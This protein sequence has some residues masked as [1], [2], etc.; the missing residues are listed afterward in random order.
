MRRTTLALALFLLGALFAP[1]A[2]GDASVKIANY[3]FSPGSVSIHTG[4]KVTWNWTG[5]DKNHTVTSDPGQAESF[6]SHPGMSIIT[7]GP[8]GETFSHT[9]THTGKFTYY[10]RVHTYMT[11]TVNVSAPGTPL[12]PNDT[13]PPATTL[14]IVRTTPRRAARSGKLKV[15]VTVS[16]AATETL[17]ARLGRRKIGKK[18]VKFASAGTKTVR[19]KLTRKGKRA[20]R[21]RRRAK[22]SVKAT[23]VDSAGNKKTARTKLTLGK[24][25]SS[26]SPTPPPSSPY[27]Y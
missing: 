6:E 22:V 13:S 19:I 24:K 17:V 27:S 3:S 8:P 18:T 12:K 25:K 9:F 2:L 23:G 4:E 1:P 15:K 7:D 10:C 26:S 21:K 14:R 16:E 20:L 11:G 5:S